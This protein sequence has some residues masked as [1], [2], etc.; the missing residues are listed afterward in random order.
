VSKRTSTKEEAT[1]KS[2]LNVSVRRPLEDLSMESMPHP[3]EHMGRDGWVKEQRTINSSL[4]GSISDFSSR[5]SYKHFV[6]AE[7]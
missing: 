2:Q 5:L 4:K 1:F 7:A 3:Q 6:A